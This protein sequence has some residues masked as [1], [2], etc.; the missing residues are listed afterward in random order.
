[1]SQDIYT[2]PRRVLQNEASVRPRLSIRAPQG[3]LYYTHLP[4]QRGEKRRDLVNI[5]TKAY[6]PLYLL[7]QMTVMWRLRRLDCWFVCSCM[8][9]LCRVQQAVTCD[10]TLIDDSL[11]F[12]FFLACSVNTLKKDWKSD[13][14]LSHILVWQI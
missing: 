14:K 6:C 9:L 7:S 5:L 4:P 1:M 2:L 13:C 8:S 3:L 10:W 12:F 11:S